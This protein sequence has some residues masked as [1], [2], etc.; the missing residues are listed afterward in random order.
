MA[1]WVALGDRAIRFARPA[2]V[3]PQQLVQAAR[4]WPGVVDVVIARDDMAVYF[5][6]TPAVGDAQIAALAMLGNNP[7]TGRMHVFRAIYDGPDLEA[8]SAL[9]GLGV[10]DIITMHSAGMYAVE[11][12]GFLPGFAY[13]TGLQP[14]LVVPRRATPRTRV[15]ANTIAIAAGYTS[16]YPLDSPGG[17]HLIGSVVDA[18]PLF[19]P[20]GTLLKLGDAVRFAR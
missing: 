7:V 11:T 6:D 2:N 16:I 9:T 10:D 13:M 4:A 15:P 8:V 17:W 3:H 12:M 14:H 19:G 5:A 18:P 1:E 20:E